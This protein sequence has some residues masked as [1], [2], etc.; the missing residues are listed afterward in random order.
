MP[1]TAI[2]VALRQNPMLGGDVVTERPVR[3][4]PHRPGSI[5]EYERSVVAGGSSHEQAVEPPSSGPL[6]Q[7]PWQPRILAN[8][9]VWLDVKILLR[10]VPYALPRRGLR[11]EMLAGRYTRTCR[12]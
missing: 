5:Q 4:E 3:A 1:G 8:W 7:W 6:R 2:P 12:S 10:T 9:S 11:G